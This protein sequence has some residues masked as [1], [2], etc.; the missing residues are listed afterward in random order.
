MFLFHQGD[1][2]TKY[3]NAKI[4]EEKKQKSEFKAL[5]ESNRVLQT[6]KRNACEELFRTLLVTVAFRKSED[7]GNDDGDMML[8]GN[9]DGG[10]SN[11]MKENKFNE[12]LSSLGIISSVS[13]GDGDGNGNEIR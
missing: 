7:I 10:G 1:N 8:M 4:D 5:P 13:E 12:S 6:F 9:Y 11:R 3:W 2:T